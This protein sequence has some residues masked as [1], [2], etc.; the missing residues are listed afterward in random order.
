MSV[1][2]QVLFTDYKQMSMSRHYWVLPERLS[3]FEDS[4]AIE[5]FLY[6]SWANAHLFRSG[7]VYEGLHAVHF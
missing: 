7:F 5:L 2:F 1:G 4:D 6:L 3:L